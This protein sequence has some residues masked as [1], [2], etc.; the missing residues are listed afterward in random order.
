MVARGLL[1]ESDDVFY[2]TSDE[3]FSSGPDLV[4]TVSRRR[5]ERDRLAKLHLPLR[6]M[7]PMDLSESSEPV[8]PLRTISGVPAVSGVAIGRVR[9]LRSPDDEIEPGEVLVTRV[10]DTGWTPFFGAAAAVVTD[11]G[12]SMSHASIVA[13]EFGI[14]A[15]VGTR[16][17]SQILKDG[18]LVE[19]NGATGVVTVLD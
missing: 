14:P 4:A 5:A 17:G 8:G 12:G 16:R 13:R 10:T 7:Q 15:V 1:V 11:I 9:V 2:L 19:V 3:V 18:Q 6:F